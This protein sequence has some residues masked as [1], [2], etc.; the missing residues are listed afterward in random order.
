[1]NY[2]NYEDTIVQGRKV[3]I[4]G[5]PTSVTF[6]SPSTIGN[7]KDM[8]TLHDGWMA[9]TIRWVRMTSAE[10]QAHAEDLQERRD[11]GQIV[12]KKCKRRTT[13]KRPTTSTRCD[14]DSSVSSEDDENTPLAPRPAKRTRG[15]QR[16]TRARKSQMPPTSKAIITDSGEDEEEEGDA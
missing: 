8:R 3:K 9:G 11:E 15:A 5:W 13:K 4:T 6:A 10:V 1:M 16:A 7:L 2:A 14:D 12:G